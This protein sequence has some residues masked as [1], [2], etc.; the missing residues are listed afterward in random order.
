MPFGRNSGDQLNV[1]LFEVVMTTSLGA[2]LPTLTQT[3]ALHPILTVPTTLTIDDSTRST[4]E[5]NLHGAVHTIGGRALRPINY[6]GDWGVESRFFGPFGGTGVQREKRFY[7]EVVRLS[8]AVKQEDVDEAF[9]GNLGLDISS[10]LLAGSLARYNQLTDS[11]AVNL[12]DFYNGIYRQ[13]EVMSYRKTRSYTRGGATGNINYSL[14]LREI[15]PLRVPLARVAA[16]SGLLEAVGVF[17]DLTDIVKNTDVESI[18]EG[19]VSVVALPLAITP[20]GPI[21]DKVA[22]AIRLLGP[23][24]ALLDEDARADLAANVSTMFGDLQT[25]IAELGEAAAII[26]ANSPPSFDSDKGAMPF[27]TLAL[28]D[29]VPALQAFEE[30][31]ELQDAKDALE[32]FNIA[33]VFGAWARQ[34]TVR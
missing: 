22:Q 5:R 30:E 23:S 24:G 31:M 6:Q 32:A 17:Q 26:S 25:S 9:A 2:D 12:Y 4:V 21:A 3:V 16:L 33:G 13:V 27:G 1:I 8:G 28:E 20:L 7:S 19:L 14:S 11:F 29:D 34:N 18:I 10:A 15:G